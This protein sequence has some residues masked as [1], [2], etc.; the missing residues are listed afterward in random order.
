[1]ISVL[2]LARGRETHLANLVLGLTQQTRAPGELV[3][4]VMQPDLYDLPAAEFPVRQIRIAGDPVPLAEARNR[5]AR[6]AAGDRLVFLDVDC[7]PAPGLVAD[8]DAHLDGFE[9][10][11][12]GEV[13][14]AP[15]GA[16]APGWRYDGLDAVAV[17][18]AD[19]GGPPAAGVEACTDY[20]CFWSLNFAMIRDAFDRS[21]GFDEGY[22]GYGGEDTDFGRTLFER[23]IPLGFAKGALAYHQYHPH[24][25]PPVHHLESVLVNAERFKDKWGYHTMDHWLRA[26]ELMGLIARDGEGYRVLREPNEADLALTRQQSH[27]PYASSAAILKRLEAGRAAPSPEAMST[28]PAMASA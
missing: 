11:V 28:A 1:M 15:E 27:Q 19:R 21:G 8:Y 5:V 7:I 3:I 13:L 4:G 10:A 6:E 16:A 14:Y 12:M 25:M 18:H 22:E 24:H 17:K 9:G 23:G 2:T 20:R 26:F